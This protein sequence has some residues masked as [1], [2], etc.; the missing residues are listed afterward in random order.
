VTGGP[1]LYQSINNNNHVAKDVSAKHRSN[2]KLNDL[3]MFS[4]AEFES[5]VEKRT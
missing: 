2:K 3:Q 4:S 5:A 1:I